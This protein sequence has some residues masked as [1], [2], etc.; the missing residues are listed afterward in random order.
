[1]T[2]IE[3]NFTIELLNVTPARFIEDI[4]RVLSDVQNFQLKLKF[5]IRVFKYF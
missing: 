4:L 3:R 5:G 2:V 1:M